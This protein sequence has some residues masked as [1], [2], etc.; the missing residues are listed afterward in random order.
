MYNGPLSGLLLNVFNKVDN[1]A[2]SG[3][4]ETSAFFWRVFAAVCLDSTCPS[5]SE[6]LRGHTP[7]PIVLG[8]GSQSMIMDPTGHKPF[9]CDICH[10]RFSRKD[11]LKRHSLNKHSS[12]PLAHECLVCGIVFRKHQS[13]L[14]HRKQHAND[15]EFKQVESALGGAVKT[16]TRRVE[17]GN[18]DIGEVQGQ[19][20][21]DALTIMKNELNNCLRIKTSLIIL[22]ELGKQTPDGT[23][24]DLSTIPLRSRSFEAI[25]YGDT[26]ESLFNS[27][28]QIKHTLSNFNE[29]GSAWIILNILEVRLEI[30]QCRPL[31]G[32][33]G[34]VSVI[35]PKKLKNLR[36]DAN[37]GT[38][39]CFYKAV[40]AYF[41]ESDDPEKLE[42]F[43]EQNIVKLKHDQDT[44]MEVR[45]I[46]HFE[47][48]NP[49]LSLRINVLGEETSKSG[50]VF[51]PLLFSK[52]IEA[53]NSI[54]LI[55][56]NVFRAD[57]GKKV[58]ARH[59]LLARDL[60][61]LLRT[62]YG[63]AEGKHSYQKTYPCMNCLVRFSSPRLLRAHEKNC[64]KNDPQAV[65]LSERPDKI[66]FSNHMSKFKHPYIGFLDMESK[67]VNS[68][69]KCRSC[70]NS[71]QCAHKSK[72][73]KIQ[74]PISYCLVILDMNE[75]VVFDR[76]YVGEDCVEDLNETLRA[77]RKKL[78]KIIEKKKPLVMSPEDELKFRAASHCHICEKPFSS[79]YK[80]E[81]LQQQRERLQK[82]DIVWKETDE[83][84]Q[85]RYYI[86]TEEFK[87]EVIVRDHCHINGDFLGAAHQGCNLNRR[88]KT[89]MPVPI[90]CHNFSGV[91]KINHSQGL[92][93]LFFLT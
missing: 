45:Q 47:E 27:F 60:S 20:S 40:A 79:E 70:G 72:I 65:T 87:K 83:T 55:L 12:L 22:F 24:T 90:Y 50:S 92:A 93:N 82:K 88:I 21:E 35:H 43:I 7:S 48:K 67:S 56:I 36:L 44:G 34:E 18:I 6:I 54:N 1:K 3:S 8:P 71:D 23:I 57:R 31:N 16:F 61:K 2:L 26:R 42:K 84:E 69:T 17:T 28:E 85:L 15:S 14:Q 51:F 9:Q 11:T 49:A 52:N 13:L 76:T 81:T 78:G 77:A 62:T 53:E 39:D 38:N 80:L 63:E 86:P 74:T 37:S 10:T 19:V 91:L 58:L 32:Q 66:R 33:C 4:N 25:R 68:K 29:N 73:E 41:T 59:Y 5:M 30:G 89:T 64:M 46:K 75:K